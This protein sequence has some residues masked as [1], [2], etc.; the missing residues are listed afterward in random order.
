MMTK[1]V[2][3]IMLI[4]GA[5]AVVLVPIAIFVPMFASIFFIVPIEDVYM[6]QFLIGMFVLLFGMIFVALGLFMSP[7]S[8]VKEGKSDA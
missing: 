8:V 4:T 5:I 2:E 3:G 1:L 6:F 7:D